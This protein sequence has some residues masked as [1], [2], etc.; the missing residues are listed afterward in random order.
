M[1]LSVNWGSWSRNAVP[2]LRPI[3][4]GHPQNPEDILCQKK[5]GVD[6]IVIF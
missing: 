4:G 2:R 6:L 3:L 5:A 1:L